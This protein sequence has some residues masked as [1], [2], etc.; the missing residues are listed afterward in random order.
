MAAR[1]IRSASRKLRNSEATSRSCGGGGGGRGGGGRLGASGGRRGWG[2]RAGEHVSLPPRRTRPRTRWAS[3]Q[4]A[5]QTHTRQAAAACRPSQLHLAEELLEEGAGQHV[6]GNRVGDCCEHPVELAWG[7]ETNWA[8]I[9][10]S[11]MFGAVSANHGVYSS[12]A[13]LAQ[14]QQ[15]RRGTCAHARLASQERCGRR[16]TQRRLAVGLLA[17]DAVDELFSDALVPQQ[18]AGAEPAQRDLAGRGGRERSRLW[19]RHCC[20]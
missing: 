8:R 3:E 5:M 15:V 16:L 14:P 1:M 7:Q 9:A 10:R 19:G 12:A 13:L 4:R 11:M 6:P 20:G 17:G 18:R 2:G